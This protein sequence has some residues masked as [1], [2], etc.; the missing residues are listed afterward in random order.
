M[1]T[2]LIV[3]IVF[4]GIIALNIGV[5]IAT[6]RM[7]KRFIIENKA[8]CL[9]FVSPAELK[10][11]MYQYYLNQYMENEVAEWKQEIE[12]V[13]MKGLEGCG[14]EETSMAKILENFLREEY[15]K[16]QEKI[17]IIEKKNSKYSRKK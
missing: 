12:I 14:L 7:A 4:I 1:K 5:Y 17:E 6:K 11:K 2:M 13:K 10:E 15:D 3:A 9:A 16:L 8:L